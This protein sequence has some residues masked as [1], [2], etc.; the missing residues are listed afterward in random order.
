MLITDIKVQKSR[1]NRFSI[2]IDG[3]YRF[4]LDFNTIQQVGLH[5][6]DEIDEKKIDELVR[7]DEYA[8]CRDYALLLL[9]YRDRSESELNN[10]LLKKGFHHDVAR[11]LVGNLKKEGIVN[12]FAFASKWVEDTC[13]NRPM[14]RMRAVFELR[15]KMLSD[16]IIEAVIE[17][18]FDGNT[19]QR[20]AHSAAEKKMKSL[21]SYPPDTAQERLYRFLKNRGFQ[22]DIINGLMKEYFNDH[23]G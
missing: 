20:L 9:S 7:R 13:A 5:V 2:Y 14:G 11:E 22:F 1:K 19:E 8:R 17:E 15:K 4:S 21:E 16:G 10:R 12:D 3:K 18:K 6:G 23:I